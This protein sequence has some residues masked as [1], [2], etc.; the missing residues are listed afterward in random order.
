[1]DIHMP[2]MDG[3]EAASKIIEL[4]EVSMTL[5]I[6]PPPIVAVTANIMSNDLELYRQ[7]GMSDCLGKPFTAQELWRCLIKFLPVDSFTDVDNQSMSVQDEQSLK[8]LKANFVKE[9]KKKF[10]E[11]L[12]ALE[13]DDVK[14]AHRIAHS[15]KSNAGQIGKKNL[16]QAAADVERHLKDGKNFVTPAQMATLEKEINLVLSQISDEMLHFTDQ[17]PS[18]V[19]NTPPKNSNVI[20]SPNELINKL[21][22]LLRTGNPECIK[23]IESLRKINGNDELK[24][25][26]IQQIDDFEFEAALKTLMELS[27]NI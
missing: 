19:N 9:N 25:R 17:E 5:P 1:M 3:L 12:N 26:L 14:A 22:T 15:L 20:D 13:F 23:L 8:K 24:D 11:F 27:K 21:E 10:D 6:K 2:V 16:Q 18:Q 4:F 7:S